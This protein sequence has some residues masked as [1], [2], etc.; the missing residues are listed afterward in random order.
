[1]QTGNLLSN[2]SVIL[3][4]AAV[5]DDLRQR[6]AAGPRPKTYLLVACLFAVISAVLEIWPR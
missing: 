6:G 1:M 4:A 5:W 3:V 2:M